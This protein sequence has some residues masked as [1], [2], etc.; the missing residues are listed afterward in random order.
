M[1]GVTQRQD[2]EPRVKVHE[3]HRRVVAIMKQTPISSPSH[4][5]YPR[6]QR[7]QAAL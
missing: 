6:G 5:L 7:P 3:E 4:Y 2:R 1:E